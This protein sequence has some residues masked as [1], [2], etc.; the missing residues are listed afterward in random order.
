[1]HSSLHIIQFPT[2]FPEFTSHECDLTCERHRIAHK[3]CTVDI[4]TWLS[5]KS[6][7]SKLEA[8]GAANDNPNLITVACADILLS[9][10]LHILGVSLDSR[11]SCDNQI[12]AVCKACYFYIHI[13]QHVSTSL[14]DKV[15]NTAPCS[16]VSS[17]LDYCNSLFADMSGLNL[18]H[19][20]KVQ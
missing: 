2:D 7:P 12:A 16:I 19:L 15:A 9:P 1:M 11:L 3:L 17:R 10:V 6:L 20:Q 4:Y 14:S 8:I 13:L 5:Y 18:D